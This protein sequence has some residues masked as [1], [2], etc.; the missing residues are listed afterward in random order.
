MIKQVPVLALAAAA[1]IAEP[2]PEHA[3]P[4]PVT[5]PPAAPAQPSPPAG[6]TKNMI[7]LEFVTVL[8]TFKDAFH[9]DVTILTDGRSKYCVYDIPAGR[10][11][12]EDTIP[13]VIIVPGR[14]LEILDN[15]RAYQWF[16]AGIITP[17]MLK[18]YRQNHD[19]DFPLGD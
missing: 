7:Y 6:L 13:K 16:S 12:T 10:Y 4:E 3:A 8:G 2:A 11:A 19:L 18:K 5:P 17:E 9:Y 1:A 15:R 14:V